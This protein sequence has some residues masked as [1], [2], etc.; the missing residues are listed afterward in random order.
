MV[1]GII[2]LLIAI[3]VPALNRARESAKTV[4]CAAQLRQ[5][6]QAIFNYASSNKGMLPCWS[7]EHFYPDDPFPIDESGPGWTLLLERYIGAKPDSRIWT[8]PAFPGDSPEITYFLEAKWEYVQQPLLR[9]I[10]I[11]RIHNSAQFVLSGDVTV[12][13]WYM[14]SFGDYDKGHD[15]IDKDDG[16]TKCIAFFGEDDG[17]NLHRAGNNILFADGHVRAFREYSRQEMTYHPYRFLNWGE[18]EADP[19][20]PNP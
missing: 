19:V 15:D 18:V 16:K 20:Q 5:V 10:P 12:H 8:C 3:L 7:A 4:Q 11:S 6:G 14:P 9:S 13:S 2:A 17:F 1:I